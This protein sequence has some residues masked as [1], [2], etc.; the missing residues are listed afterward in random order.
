ML[1]FKMSGENK[2]IVHFQKCDTTEVIVLKQFPQTSCRQIKKEICY[3]ESCPLVKKE[4]CKHYIHE[5]CKS[6][7]TQSEFKFTKSHDVFLM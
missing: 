7:S 4:V 3:E 5:H 6:L 1:G 2:N